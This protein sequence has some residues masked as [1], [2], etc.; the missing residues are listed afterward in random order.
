MKYYNTEEDIQRDLK[1]LSLE[2]QI[3]WEELKIIKEDFKEAL[4]PS[5]WLQTG[6]KLFSKLGLMMLVK[7]IIK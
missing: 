4:Q 1:R 5:H 2:K 7:K 3:A 6:F